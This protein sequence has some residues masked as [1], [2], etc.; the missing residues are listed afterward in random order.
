MYTHSVFLAE[1]LPEYRIKRPGPVVH[2]PRTILLDW[3]E[4]GFAKRTNREVWRPSLFQLLMTRAVAAVSRIRKCS[5][6]P[7]APLVPGSPSSTLPHSEPECTSVYNLRT[8][9]RKGR[10]QISY[11]D[12]VYAFRVAMGVVLILGRSFNKIIYVWN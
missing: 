7:K 4:V 11:V 6:P 5:T 3:I 2:S 9:I 1:V 10:R 12:T 8:S